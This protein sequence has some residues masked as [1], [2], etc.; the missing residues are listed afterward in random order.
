VKAVVSDS[1]PLR[2]LIVCGCA[3]VLAR[4]FETVIVPGEVI[5]EMSHPSAPKVVQAWAKSPPAWLRIAPTAPEPATPGQHMG[6]FAAIRLALQSGIKTLLCDDL[7]ARRRAASQGLEVLGTLGVLEA[8]ANAGLLDLRAT[9]AALLNT[10]FRIS[11]NLV[12]ELQ[13]R[14]G[15]NPDRKD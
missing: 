6:E 15:G 14:A 8:A 10:N 9:L 2:Y 11:A 13:E 1:G 7:A 5:S 12:R 4:L 3:E